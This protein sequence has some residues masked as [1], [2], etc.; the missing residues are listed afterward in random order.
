[1]FVGLALRVLVG[2]F[3]NLAWVYGGYDD[4]DDDDKD[5]H[6]D[7]DGGDGG[8]ARKSRSVADC[9]GGADGCA[10]DDVVDISADAQRRGLWASSYESHL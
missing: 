3:L 5:G 4:G 10:D 1:M 8:D 2:R 6:D 7:G 9:R